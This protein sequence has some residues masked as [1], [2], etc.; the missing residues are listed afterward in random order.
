MRISELARANS[1]NE[2]QRPFPKTKV[3]T[4]GPR[5]SR[6]SESRKQP[7]GAL[8]RATKIS[9]PT[10]LFRAIKNLEKSREA[11]IDAN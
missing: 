10:G 4:P 7:V 2:T 9:K 6:T 11:L 8:L 5:I 3:C 1:R